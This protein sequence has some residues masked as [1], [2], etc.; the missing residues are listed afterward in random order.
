V[1]VAYLDPFSGVSGDLLLGALVDVGVPL[2]AL[3]AAVDTLGV[4][5]LTLAAHQVR[6]NG[7]AA[8][9]VEVS[10]PPQHEHR[11]LREIVVMIGSS[12]LPPETIRQAVAVFTRLAEIEAAVHRV[13]PDEVHFHEVGA[14]DALADVVGAVTGIRLLNVDD[15]LVGPVNVGSGRVKCAHGELPVPAPATLGLL[16]GW[17]CYTAGPRRELTTP[18]G[19]ALV[20]T[21]GRQLETMP[22]LRVE[23][24]GYGAADSDPP[25]WPNVL[26]LIVGEETRVGEMSAAGEGTACCE[27][28][29]CCEGTGLGE[30]T[31]YGEGSGA[32]VG[33]G[34]A[35]A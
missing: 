21:L 35:G 20:T 2:E 24:A 13:T 25:G 22:A 26:R 7:I 19:A 29:G 23:A 4:E 30:G 16:E 9:K 32:G 18:T 27:G 34:E 17:T 31:G 12:G 11:R 10:F 6:R 14:A 3:Q 8:T 1:K 33:S 15:L 5:A 28:A